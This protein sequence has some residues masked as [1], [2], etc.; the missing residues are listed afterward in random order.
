MKTIQKL[1]AVSAMAVF[2]IGILT[3]C[4][5]RCSTCSYTF[6]D[7][8]L[9]EQT[10]SVPEVCGTKAE[11]DAYKTSTEAAAALVNGTVS[12]VDN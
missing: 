9:G 12:C 7:P 11:V 1:L 8:I 6:T 5:E 3:G 4:G 2:S 10:T